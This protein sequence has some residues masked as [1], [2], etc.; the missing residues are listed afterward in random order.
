MF[1]LLIFKLMFF[2][3]LGHWISGERLLRNWV[4]LTPLPRS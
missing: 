1:A 2:A 4:E 3:M